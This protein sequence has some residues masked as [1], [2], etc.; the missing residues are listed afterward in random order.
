MKRREFISLLGGVAVAPSQFWP[1]EARAQQFGGMRR[2]GVLWAGRERDPQYELFGAAFLQGLRDA[3]WSDGVNARIEQRWGAGDPARL[4]A[5]A[6][7]L[8]K[9][10][11]DAIL[12]TSTAALAALLFE[13][14]TIPVIFVNVS[15]PVA[16]GFVAS[17]AQPGANATGF[18]NFEYAISGK[19]LELLKEVAP[20]VVRAALIQ[21]LDNPN[22]PRYVRASEAIAPSLRLAVTRIG[23]LDLDELERVVN[24]FAQ[25]PN[26]G[27]IVLPSPFTLTN[28][29]SI[30]ALTARH[31][32][33]TVYP[34]RF[35]AL[36][37]GLIS[38]GSDANDL[39]RRVASY[40]D[41][42]LRG[43]KPADLPVQQ[44]T[45]YELVINLKAAKAL[46][47]DVPP[48]LLAR[49]DEVIE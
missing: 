35:F 45:K 3:G 29:E 32:L 38:Y 43:T 40:V 8:V 44:P 26:C 17:L 16:G 27:V 6:A 11:P 28:R 48:T 46:R 31:G 7:E 19:W 47:L 2:I 10:A 22:W 13:T 49:A 23:V 25:E 21:N 20:G 39:F 14:R 42:I 1:R 15:D 9:S 34:H 30:V 4:R 41:R 24:A 37:G 18:T 5:H 12:A 36:S 33:P